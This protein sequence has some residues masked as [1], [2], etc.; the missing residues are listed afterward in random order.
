MKTV[1]HTIYIIL[2]CC[3][4]T[5]VSKSEEPFAQGSYLGQTTPG[6]VAEVFAA[7]LICCSGATW[8]SHGSF[9]LDGNTFCYMRSGTVMIS[10]R[11]EQGWTKPQPV[12]GLPDKIWSPQ[13]APDGTALYFST[14]DLYR[15]KRTESGWAAPEKLPPAVSSNADEWG[16]SLA[17]DHTLYFCSHRPGGRGGCDIWTAPFV[18]LSWPAATPV[19]AVDTGHNDCGPGV[20]ADQSFMVLWSNRPGGQGGFDLYLCRRRP[21]GTWSEAE[22]LGPGVNTPRQEYGAHVSAN[23]EILFFTRSDGWN[24]KTH[25]ADIYWVDITTPE[26]TTHD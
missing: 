12:P 5:G 19:T 22:N 7:D 9:S 23:G 21:D 18:D 4:L 1:N 10:N 16:F 15:C 11:K 25:A 14:R 20:A 17:A 3:L 2:L 24:P 8:E 13:V 26:K 6:P